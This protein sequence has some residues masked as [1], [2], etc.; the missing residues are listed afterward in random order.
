MRAGTGCCKSGC[1]HGE[2]GGGGGG[3]AWVRWYRGTR[4][5]GWLA[6]WP[7]PVNGISQSVSTSTPAPP[8]GGLAVRP[9]QAHSD[10]SE[11]TQTRKHLDFA[12]KI[13][14]KLDRDKTQQPDR[15]V[16]SGCRLNSPVLFTTGLCSD[17]SNC[18]PV[19]STKVQHSR[20]YTRQLVGLS[21]GKTSSNCVF[22]P[23]CDSCN[24]NQKI[25]N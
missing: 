11:G 9:G 5:L 14:A 24:S 17:D 8:Q 18:E 12:L 10:C 16:E 22:L 19:C 13:R 3:S 15:A 6:G 23:S 25:F 1:Y 21:D 4:Y 20:L 7:A 2:T